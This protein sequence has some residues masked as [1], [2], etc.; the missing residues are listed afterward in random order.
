MAVASAPAPVAASGAPLSRLLW[1][2]GG[3]RVLWAVLGIA[4][5]AVA[6]LPLV[7][8]IDA[9][10]YR[11]TRTGLSTER[12][13][14]AV[15]DVYATA[16]Y[17]GYLADA[18]ILA[19][20]VTL[21]SLLVGMT[22]A[23]LMARTDLPF[24]NTFDLLIIM[25]LFLSPFTGLI[26]WIALGS[27]KTGFINVTISAALGA[28]GLDPGPLINI[29]NYAGVVWVMFLFFCPFAYLFTVGNLR[30]MDSSLEE[31][32]RTT[33]ATP[34][35]TLLRVTVP[36]SV[37]AILA[38]GLLIFILAAEMYTIP[39]IIGSTAGFTT[40]PWKIYQ[41]A[42]V[43]PV[44]SAHAAAGATMLLWITV[45]GIWLQRRVTRRSE[46][47]VTVTGKGFRGRPL[48]LG[49]WRWLALLFIGLYVLS[50]DILPFGALLLSSFMKYSA[51]MISADIFTLKHYVQIFTL[52]NIRDSIWNTLYLAVLSGGLCVLAGLLISFMEVRRP[53]PS[54]K[55]LAFFGVL[56]VAVPG[57][58]YGLGLIWTYVQT[59]IY[60]TVWVL[61]LAYVAKFL[62]YGIVVSRSAIL[63]VHPELEQCARISGASS[64]KTL[65]AITMPLLKP[66]LIA[67]LFFVMLMSIKELSASL[68]LYTQKSQVLSVLTWHYMDAGNYQFASALG[69][70]QTL[71]MMALVVATRAIFNVQLEKTLAKS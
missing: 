31:A 8:T 70:I 3:E 14:R 46:R 19:T 53:S 38:S 6:I 64:L 49:S 58:V 52:Q 36:M 65:R 68:L 34:L 25:P 13:L 56:P 35:Q 44:H 37:P 60:G 4:V 1:R 45:F 67:I 26:A 66:T 50:A 71:I 69:V 47:Y 7:Y 62:P 15:L 24:K 5:F 22:M 55:L 11:E 41:D 33:G 21:S 43:F 48:P 10:F 9:S 54:T 16:A 57:L 2:W 51:P 18:L 32:A 17:L 27:E 28:I 39:G 29:W 59:P 40:L 42:T 23:L 30:A 20:V 61:L 63:Q 12:S